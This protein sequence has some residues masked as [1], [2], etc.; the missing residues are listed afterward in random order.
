M[1]KEKNN[2][3]FDLFADY[4]DAENLVVGA[5]KET[6]EENQQGE[7]SKKSNRIEDFGE[8]IGGARKDLYAAYYDLIKTATEEEI[9]NEPLSKTFPEPKYNKLLEMGVEKWKVDAVRVLRETIPP[10][11]KKYSWFIEQWAIE[12]SVLRDI[13]ISVLEDKWTQ[14]EFLE[15]I[16]K[17]NTKNRN[18][19]LVQRIRN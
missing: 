4:F 1:R 17:S 6:V 3:E 5:V 13:S 2:V 8:K 9:E 14:E 7:S 15:E 11:P 12:M 19:I 10:K 18:T 16:K